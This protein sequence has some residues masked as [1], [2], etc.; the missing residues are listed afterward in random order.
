MPLF[1]VPVARRLLWP[2]DAR[3]PRHRAR[4]VIRQF[5]A[6]F[7]SIIYDM[8]LAVE[9]ANAQA[10][11]AGRRKYVRLYGGLVRHRKIGSAGLALTLAHETGHHLGGP[12]YLRGLPVISSEEQATRWAMTCALPLVFGITRATVIAQRGAVELKAVGIPA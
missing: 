6:S 8:D 11:R 2:T 7:P 3:W 4:A 5:Q 10:F 12:P 1:D 9:L